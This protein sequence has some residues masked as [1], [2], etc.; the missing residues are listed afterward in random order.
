LSVFRASDVAIECGDGVQV[1]GVGC[2]VGFF[3]GY[4]V[5][6]VLVERAGA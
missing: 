1:E 2:L 3:L 4:L 5:F 6:G